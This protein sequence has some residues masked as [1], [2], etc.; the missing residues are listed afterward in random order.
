MENIVLLIINLWNLKWSVDVLAWLSV[1]S[2]VQIAYLHTD[3]TAIP[4]PHHLLP[5]LNPDCFYLSGTV[6]FR[7]SWKRGR[8]MEKWRKWQMEKWT[9]MIV[10]T[11]LLVIVLSR[12]NNVL[13][14][15]CLSVWLAIRPVTFIVLGHIAALASSLDVACC[16]NCVDVVW[17]VCVG[18][19]VCVLSFVG[20]YLQNGWTD[21]GAF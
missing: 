1:W 2:E 21:W 13:M 20:H 4:K 18:A 11:C 6:L 16:Y 15:P 19:R 7:L 5:H 10:V 8:Q 12:V 14:V 17:S 3:A 9:V